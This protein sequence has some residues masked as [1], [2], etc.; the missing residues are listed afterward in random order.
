MRTSLRVLSM[1]GSVLLVGGLTSPL[2]GRGALAAPAPATLQCPSG[3]PLSHVIA[4]ARFKLLS[5][6]V[7][8]TGV[9]EAVRL[10]PGGT[11]QIDVLLD[12]QFHG[13]LGAGNTRFRHGRLLLEFG[14]RGAARGVQPYARGTRI[15]FAG[16]LLLN[17]NHG[18][19]EVYPVWTMQPVA[20]TA[21]PPAGGTGATG[22]SSGA[23]G[24]YGGGSGGA[25]GS[26]PLSVVVVVT[27]K[28]MPRS[29]S[30]ALATAY[31]TAGASCTASIS[32]A[33]ASNPLGALFGFA[34]ETA[35]ADGK[36]TWSWGL[37]YNITGQGSVTVTCTLN[38]QTATGVGRF[39]VG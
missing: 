24:T 3:N 37:D 31:T 4:P 28:A 38:G 35:G 17:L 10:I 6:C 1:L 27:P 22:G 39:T 2:A 13:L 20:K 19:N 26:Q 21:T 32:Y 9:V 29:Y 7:S 25:S 14:A 15:H 34:T 18:W 5:R 30:H 33:Q 12:P 8:A 23:G 11:Y 16:A 36:V